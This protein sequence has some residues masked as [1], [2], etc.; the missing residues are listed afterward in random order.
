MNVMMMMMMMM[1][2]AT[3]LCSG[4][5]RGAQL[6]EAQRYWPESRGLD[7]DYVIGIFH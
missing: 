5:T 1:M 7:S 2:I 4:D 6:V 3:T